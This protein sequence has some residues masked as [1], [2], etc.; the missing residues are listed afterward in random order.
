MLFC[1]LLGGFF[2]GLGLLIFVGRTGRV[3]RGLYGL[4]FGRM[5]RHWRRE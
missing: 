1:A 4:F 2:D 3:H 5:L